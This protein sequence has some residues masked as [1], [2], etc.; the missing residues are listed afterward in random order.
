MASRQ[1]HA[2]SARALC[3]IAC[4]FALGVAVPAAQADRI[5][6][7]NV[8]DAETRPVKDLTAADFIV[9]ED[10]VV[11][12]IVDVRVAGEPLIVSVVVDAPPEAREIRIALSAFATELL[13]ASP[14]SQ[15]SIGEFGG[16]VT[17][18]AR[19]TSSLSD[20]EK[21]IPKAIPRIDGAS[22]LSQALVDAGRELAT[23]P[24][25]RKAIV[26]INVEPSDDASPLRAKVVADQIQRSRASLWAISIVPGAARN[27]NR[28]LLLLGIANN[29]GG[30]RTTVP[31]LAALEPALRNVAQHMLFT[32]AVTFKPGESIGPAKPPHVLV[33]R[34]GAHAMT[35]I[36]PPK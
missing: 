8:M 9:R 15:I 29:S 32:Y 26:S 24:G 21:T 18:N 36:W 20:F 2:P 30:L 33:N 3:L 16:P 6:H 5:I 13:S 23:R 17:A 1:R 27:Q 4:T 19:F 10:G 34:Q 11:R 14:E 22:S 35:L 31:S 12:D 7:V 25:A 28:D